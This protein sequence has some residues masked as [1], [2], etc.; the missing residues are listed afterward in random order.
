MLFYCTDKFWGFY[1]WDTQGKGNKLIDSK[2]ERYE[3][4][5]FLDMLKIIIRK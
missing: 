3:E 1:S 5:L 4:S 2:L